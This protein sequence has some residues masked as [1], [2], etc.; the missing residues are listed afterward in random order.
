MAGYALDAEE[1]ARLEALLA[2]LVRLPSPDPPGDERAIAAF[3]G[4][5]LESLGF[6]VARDE[7]EPGR[8]NLV[9][10]LEGAGRCPA[11]VFSAH[12]DTMPVGD[13]AW[14]HPPFAAEIEAG[15]LYGRGAADMK[16][17]LAAMAAA[18]AKLKAS[19]TNLAGDVILA[20]S[21]GE[22]TGC[23]GAKRM[24]EQGTLADAGWLLVSEPTSLNVLTA[25][26][27]ALWLE[28][29][30]GSRTGHASGGGGDNA[31]AKLLGFI[32][33]LDDLDLV[34]APHPLLGM[35]SLAVNGLHAGSAPN[36]APDRATATLDI[37]TL[38]GMTAE[39][40][41]AALGRVAGDAI[42]FEIIDAKPPVETDPADAFVA[43][44]LAAVK[45][46]TG[47]HAETGGVHYFSDSNV[48]VPA[49]GVPRIIVG[50]GEI[51]M[52]GRHDEWVALDAV[53]D[54]AAIYAEI[55]AEL[56]AP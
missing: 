21:S 37:R 31:I 14:R 53:A 33:A 24:V 15:R 13:A 32:A 18:A 39:G 35:P 48:L 8:V 11:L 12:M 20:F 2:A 56:L 27:G 47:R 42:R 29:I 55:A 40:V 51:G 49:L 16:S 30:A 45:R 6:A 36:I 1:R 41:L 19:G 23:I 44:A 50:P 17:G 22:S 34:T 3:L 4:D 10:R 28:A 5:H 54:A 38:P 43:T 46:V 25:E 7:F 26:T 52:S 9:A